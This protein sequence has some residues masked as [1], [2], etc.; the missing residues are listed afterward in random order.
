MNKILIVEK[1]GKE[2]KVLAFSL[3][4]VQSTWEFSLL[5]FF[6]RGREEKIE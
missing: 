2:R 5:T 6:L 4:R 3:V 1:D